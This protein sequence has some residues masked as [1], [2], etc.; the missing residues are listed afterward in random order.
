MSRV[1][2]QGKLPPHHFLSVTSHCLFR[3]IH[4]HK[5]SC[6]L[7]SVWFLMLLLWRIRELLFEKCFRSQT[8]T[9]EIMWYLEVLISFYLQTHTSWLMWWICCT[10]WT[11]FLFHI[12]FQWTPEGR[13]LVT[14][15]SSGEFTLWNGLTFNFETI[16]QVNSHLFLLMLEVINMHHKQWYIDDG[17]VRTWEWRCVQGDSDIQEFRQL[18]QNQYY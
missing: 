1:C 6:S 3:D 2:D 8:R 11:G 18:L 5:V 10:S 17:I 13:R 14:G 9:L 15:A 12:C 4:Q 7:H 16:L